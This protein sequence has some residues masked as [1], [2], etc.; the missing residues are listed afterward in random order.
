MTKQHFFQLTVS[1][2]GNTGNGT[3]NYRSYERSHTIKA[4]NKT[5]ISASADPAFRG[6][7]SKYNPEEL[8]LASLSGCHMLWFLHLCADAGVIVT[9]YT[10]HP[11]GIMEENDSGGGKFTEVTLHPVVTIENKELAYKLEALHQQAHACC[12]IANSVNFKVSH[13]PEVK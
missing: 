7:H 2:T 3:T 8:L 4:E 13:L 5:I 12:F 9:E 1:W 6:D 10:D 11:T